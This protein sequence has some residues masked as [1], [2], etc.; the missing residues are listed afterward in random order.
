[1]V[2]ALYY[3]IGDNSIRLKMIR[4]SKAVIED[5]D[6]LIVDRNDGTSFADFE[7]SYLHHKKGVVNEKEDLV[8]C[9]F[10]TNG[11]FIY[12]VV[13]ER[14]IY[15]GLIFKSRTQYELFSDNSPIKVAFNNKYIAVITQKASDAKA[16][17]LI[18]RDGHKDGSRYLYAGIDLDEL[19]SMP[20]SDFD[21]KLTDDDYLMVTIND[22]SS[23]VYKYHVRDLKIQVNNVAALEN[24]EENYIRF[25]KGSDYPDN[26][27][28]FKYFFV[29]LSNQ[30]GDGIDTGG[31]LWGWIA[32]ILFVVATVAYSYKIRRN[33]GKSKD[34]IRDSGVRNND[35]DKSMVHDESIVGLNESVNDD[36]YGAE[37]GDSYGSGSSGDVQF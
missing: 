9:V 30:K 12:K 17:L 25:N 7:C 6:R 35:F 1:L 13:Y 24:F 37:D 10:A 23:I 4:K 16:K 21:L 5:R 27:V 8:A 2:F 3:R 28:P 36:A 34:L 32:L 29:H 31:S 14:N 20:P 19:S 15:A 11:P 33:I 26:K 22:G 18:Y